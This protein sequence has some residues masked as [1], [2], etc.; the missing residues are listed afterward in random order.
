MPLLNMK[1]YF[2]L[3]ILVSFFI[4]ESKGQEE[5]PAV[6]KK[7]CNFIKQVLCCSP[8]ED[9]GICPQYECLPKKYK[10]S[11]KRKCNTKCPI[12]CNEDQMRCKGPDDKKVSISGLLI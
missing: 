11:K 6:N 4:F 9:G 1:L 3:V 12:H 2:C 8:P 5:C 10:G 7:T